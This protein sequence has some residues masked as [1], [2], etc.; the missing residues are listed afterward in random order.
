MAE[1]ERRQEEMR[2]AEERRQLQEEV[3]RKILEE[4]RRL[5]L[6]RQQAA[7]MEAERQ[8]AA[9][10]ERERSEREQQYR[11]ELAE[12]ERE[13]ERRREQLEKKKM[14]LREQR[15]MRVKHEYGID[16]DD[17]SES[18]DE[19][20]SDEDTVTCAYFS[21]ASVPFS[22]FFNRANR[23]LVGFSVIARTG[24]LFLKYT[25]TRRRKPQDRI[26]KVAFN[27]NGPQDISWGSGEK[28]RIDVSQIQS[29]LWGLKTPAFEARKDQLDADL[30]FSIVADSVTLDLAATTKQTAELWVRGLRQML[31]LR[32]DD[33]Q[34]VEQEN[35][36]QQQIRTAIVNGDIAVIDAHIAA[37]H[38]NSTFSYNVCPVI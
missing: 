29:V 33:T 20:N 15:R 14:E 35:E 16:C 6:E 36:Y 28:R 31:G 10:K 26:V 4:E 34:G 1:E 8:I 19:Y 38:G 25:G 22:A 18:D 17:D 37:K 2:L 3:Q 9:E 21:F 5:A 13:L 7:Q 32:D 30:C 23:D 12:Q 24:Q 27:E 11:E